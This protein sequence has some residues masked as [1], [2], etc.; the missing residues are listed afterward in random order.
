M[1]SVGAVMLM[2]VLYCVL[3]YKMINLYLK[4]IIRRRES[5]SGENGGLGAGGDSGGA[6]RAAAAGAAVSDTCEEQGGGVREYADERCLHRRPHHHLLWPHHYLPH[7]YRSSHLHWLGA[8]SGALSG[9]VMQAEIQK[10]NDEV[11]G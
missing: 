8:G 6:V 1:L 2:C 7:S 10:A 3:A 9:K 4:M 5:E 11:K